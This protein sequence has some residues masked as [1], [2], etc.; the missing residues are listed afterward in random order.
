[1][2][3]DSGKYKAE[4]LSE[5]DFEHVFRKYSRDLYWI[6]MAYVNDDAMA[7]DIVQEAFLYIW[8]HKR[9]ITEQENLYFYLIRIIKSQSLNYLRNKKI[10]EHHE[11]ILLKEQPSI[12]HCDTDDE[13]EE[14]IAFVK[15]L[16]ESLPEGCRRIFAL[17]VIEGMSYKEVAETTN[18][19]VNTVK[20]Q[21]KIAYRKLRDNTS[22]A[23]ILWIFFKLFF[24]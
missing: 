19:S 24:C 23:P 16:I 4:V 6:A 14:K 8:S 15:Q 1:M 10:K 7:E 12:L 21:M 5:Q 2:I 22:H 13:L 3:T 18:L 20:S 17:C 9:A 11:N